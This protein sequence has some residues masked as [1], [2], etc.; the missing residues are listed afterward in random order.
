MIRKQ[1]GIISR[2]AVLGAF[3]LLTSLHLA[4][5]AE[6]TSSAPS[7]L[8]AY[9]EQAMKKFEVPGLAVA[10]VKD[11]KVV[12][13]KGYGVR[14]QGDSAWVDA[15][16]RFS[17]ASNSKAFTATALALL[18]E[19]GRL[20]WDEP[21]VRYMPWF[22][23]WDSYATRELTVRD[24]LVHRSGLSLGAGDLLWW[25]PTTYERKDV[26][27]RLRFI[28]PSTSFRSSTAYDNLLFVTAG[29]LIQA[30]SDLT[31]EEFV[32]QRILKKVGM[33]TTTTSYVKPT[34]GANIASSHARIDGKVRPIR[35]FSCD[36]ANPAA[37]INSNAED[38]S[39]WMMV[40]LNEG[41]F[42]NGS[43]LFSEETAHQLTAMVNPQPI[44]EPAPEFA[45]QRMNF[46]GYAL[47][48]QVLDYRG[49]KVV[50]HGGTLPGYV[51]RVMMIPELE[52]GVAVFTNQESREAYLSIIY[53]ILDHYLEVPSTDW[54][55]AYQKQEQRNRKDAEEAEKKAESARNSSSR[56]SLPIVNYAGTYRD[57]W[58]GDVEIT[59]EKKG[60]EISFKGTPSLVGKLEHWQYDTFVVRW[61]DR[62]LRA[63]AY[64][65]F[66]LQPDG[67]IDQV[68]MSPVSPAIDFSFD[69]QDLL[70]KP[71]KAPKP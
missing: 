21:V 17:I 68:K 10:I 3:F 29:E 58:Y 4:S 40:H 22:Q 69:F 26:V 43:R 5:A 44:A 1:F 14:K 37:G 30:V 38:M 56:P 23:M 8:D 42:E 18:V 6:P 60:L 46:R 57:A 32:S 35:P 24:L 31:W 15:Q 39:K 67:S 53:H 34:G 48:F 49:R 51:S 64:V 7:D 50:Q 13:A 45:A 71:V 28:R 55:A 9:V 25:P 41:E 16:T 65:T 54:I 59:H 11:G 61:R 27:K 62:E 12:V 2:H 20:D 47:G 19:E 52:L 33:S 66:S 70:L 36:N 63:D